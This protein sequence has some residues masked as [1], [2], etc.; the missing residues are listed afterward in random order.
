MKMQTSYLK[1]SV[2]GDAQVGKTCLTKMFVGE[3]G[4]EKYTPTIFENYSGE[5]VCR[6]KK[7]S[8]SIYDLPGQHDFDQMRKF[9]LKDSNV[10]IICY[11]VQNRKSFENVQSVW[12][13]EIRQ[14]L[15][16]SVPIVLVGILLNKK[17]VKSVS[18]REAIKVT[19][20]MQLHDYFEIYSGDNVE[21]SC[22]FSCVANIARKTKKR[23][24]SFLRRIFVK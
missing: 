20:Q 8:L 14:F 6:G 13:P 2:V 7:A 16:K 9:A 17:Q 10:I 19:S 11:N 21:V 5:T 4:E 23:N 18:R 3:K 12:I 22:L 15:G 24:F 1:C